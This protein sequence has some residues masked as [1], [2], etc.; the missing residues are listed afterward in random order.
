GGASTWRPPALAGTLYRVTFDYIP[1]HAD[2]LALSRGERVAILE[3]F[4]DGWCRGK[5]VLTDSESNLATTPS[6]ARPRKESKPKSVNGDSTKDGHGGGFDETTFTPESDSSGTFP[7]F[8]VTPVV[9][10]RREKVEA[11][12]ES[13]SRRTSMLSRKSQESKKG[14]SSEDSNGGPLSSWLSQTANPEKLKRMFT[15]AAEKDKNNDG[16]LGLKE[17]QQPPKPVEIRMGNGSV[18]GYGGKG[19][20]SSPATSS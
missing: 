18:V 7:I 6:S 10:V 12:S 16:S 1:I 15:G 11:P 3:F 17:G 4:E 20:E 14:R 2:E 9:Y 8:C 19:W 5:K 13:N